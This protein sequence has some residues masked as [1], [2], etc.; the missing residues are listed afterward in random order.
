MTWRPQK[1]DR[2]LILKGAP[3]SST[4]KSWDGPRHSRKTYEVRVHYV[5]TSVDPEGEVTVV[6]VRWAGSGGY[7]KWV[8]FEWV[9]PAPSD[10]ERLA[11][12]ADRKEKE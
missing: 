7:W 9:K 3:V 1:G 5:S 12:V 8:P 2:V 6:D 10:L 11:L 4:Q